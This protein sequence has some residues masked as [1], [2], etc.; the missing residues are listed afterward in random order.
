ME[1]AINMELGERLRLIRKEKYLTL[2]DVSQLANLS[3]PYLSAMERGAVNPS[4]ETL[5]KVA[6]AYEMKLTEL[7]VGVEDMGES[8]PEN[9]PA[10][11]S[12][13][14]SDDAY[15]DE[16]NTDWKEL[17]IGINFRGR[18]PSSKREWLELYLS[19]KRILSAQEKKVKDPKKHI[20][21]LVQD[22]VSE[23]SSGRISNFDEIC[24]NLGLDVQETLLPHGIDGMH[25]GGTILINSQI[26]NEER[27]RFTQFHE[28]THY[29][30]EKDADL[31]SD[32]HDLTFSQEGE[33]DR[34]LEKLC[35]IGAAEFLMPSEEFRKL[36]KERGFN[37]GLIP[38]AARYFKC[39]T[40]ATTIQFAQVAPNKC[41]TAICEH[42]LIPNDIAQSQDH[43]LEEKNLSVERKLH[44]VY[45]APSPTTKYWLAKYTEI[46]KE[47]L[48]NQAF[49]QTQPVEEE[50]YVPFRSGRKMPCH[51][52]ALADGN[53]I[54]VLFHLTPPP[55]PDQLTLV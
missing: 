8:A 6:K 25:K 28:L 35:N 12:E 5:Q 15:K 27:K 45:S 36:Y 2:K 1:G 44:V 38:Y 13:F 50:S 31:L 43:L 29:L 41:I 4:V 17:L 33:Y 34:Q 21:K 40:M 47:H 24:T 52:E 46:P 10:G 9:Y 18:Q 49:L 42:G 20:I 48:I 26:Q 14:L 53:R 3:V 37:V 32:L 30:I 23:Y 51:C 55:N 54:Y 7:F 11:F 22:T 19:L 39:S 16:L